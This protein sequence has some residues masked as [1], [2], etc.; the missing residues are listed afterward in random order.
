MA[1]AVAPA[2]SD[3]W[4][5]R[6]VSF[7]EPYLVADALSFGAILAGWVADIGKNLKAA[8]AVAGL[9]MACSACY[10]LQSFVELKN[11]ADAV[12]V[13]WQKTYPDLSH[14]EKPAEAQVALTEARIKLALGFFDFNSSWTEGVQFFNSVGLVVGRALAPIA[15]IGSF[16]TI[17]AD[18]IRAINDCFKIDKE[19]EG[20]RNTAEGP[21]F[22]EYHKAR[23][24]YL[25][26]DLIRRIVGI[27][28]V[29]GILVITY[30]MAKSGS[31][32][33]ARALLAISTAHILLKGINHFFDKFL[34]DQ[35]NK[36]PQPSPV[37]PTL[38]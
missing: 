34:E 1:S 5:I 24:G 33:S 16:C 38:A 32:T 35:K 13:I 23:I 36:L 28:L 25:T 15:I 11:I 6:G 12:G 18:A 8:K 29:I 31:L 26:L 22:K 4:I 3:P 2:T 27:A 19:F 14:P 10:I 7:N 17:I 30:L 20:Y 21:A 37:K 9:G